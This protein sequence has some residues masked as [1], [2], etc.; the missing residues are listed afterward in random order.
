MKKEIATKI[1][2]MQAVGVGYRLIA[3]KTGLKVD[4]V[5]KH[6]K[7]PT[8]GNRIQPPYLPIS[9]SYLKQAN[10]IWLLIY[11]VVKENCTSDYKGATP[12]DDDP[13]EH[14]L[15]SRGL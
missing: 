4:T 9:Q 14:L 5:K 1:K 2:Q 8:T 7:H 13:M 6:C 3:T 12:A 15:R 11:Q 10:S